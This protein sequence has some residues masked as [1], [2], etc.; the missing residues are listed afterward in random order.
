MKK[1]FQVISALLFGYGALMWGT[2]CAYM[3]RGYTAIG[4]E[5][6]FAVLAA[7]VAYW[8]IEKFE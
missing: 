7:I 6:I 8:L 5:Y 3:Q 1:I 2:Q 4:G